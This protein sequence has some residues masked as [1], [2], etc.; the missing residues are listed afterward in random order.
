MNFS[1]F[2]IRRPIFA[3]VLSLLIL[4][5]GA[6]ALFRLPLSEYPRVAPTTVAV[7]T[8]YPGASPEAV[9]AT[10]AAPLEQEING[11]P[12]MLYL[13]SQADAEGKMTLTVTF[14]ENVDPDLA[15]INVQNRVA[16]ALPRLPA[17]VQAMGVV[18]EKTSPDML[19]VVHL[20]SP[21][22][23]YDALHLTNF[24]LL[25]VRDE[26]QRLPGVG[27][28]YAWGAGEYAM[29]V[30]MDPAKLAARELTAGD[31]IS[32]IREQNVQVAAGSLGQSPNS[33]APFQVPIMGPARL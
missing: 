12:G 25:S 8:I 9:A 32:A 19:M 26:L 23:R 22:G 13:S 2:F 24:A 20:V 16:R 30:W 33:G 27:D 17:E 18:T 7:R 10:V 3:I 5:A 6:L 14:A 11:V 21:D 28:V 1:E 31:V 4:I 29:R 15:Q